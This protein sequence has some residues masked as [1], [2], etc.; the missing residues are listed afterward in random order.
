LEAVIERNEST[1]TRENPIQNVPVDMTE[2]AVIA[3]SIESNHLR[4]PSAPAAALPSERVEKSTDHR[5]GSADG[6]ADFGVTTAA[7]LWLSDEKTVDRRSECSESLSDDLQIPG[8]QID[9]HS[10]QLRSHLLRIYFKY[11]RLWINV[12]H[13]AV[14]MEH[15]ANGV[16]S[17]WYSTFLEAVLLACASRISTSSAVRAL[18]NEYAKEAKSSIIEALEHPS[19]ASLQGFILLSEYEVTLGHDRIGWMLSG[20]LNCVVW[21][22][23]FMTDNGQ[24]WRA[25]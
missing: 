4:H 14:F 10:A 1:V 18:G 3:P 25:E 2:D 23:W 24:V 8:V 13:K 21:K 22:L 5:D 16:A 11:Q 19:A 12:V 20:M 7:H 17:Q 6:A 15:K 9:M